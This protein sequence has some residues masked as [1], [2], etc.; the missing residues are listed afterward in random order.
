MAQNRTFLEKITTL[1]TSNIFVMQLRCTGQVQVYSC[2]TYGRAKK[3]ILV[4]NF[5]I[6]ILAGK[7]LSQDDGLVKYMGHTLKTHEEIVRDREGG[8]T[9]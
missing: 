2:E 9:G 7:L 3:Q 1:Q 8:K 4:L 6:Y 5:L